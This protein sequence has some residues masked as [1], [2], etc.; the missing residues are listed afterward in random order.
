MTTVEL[1]AML[2]SHQVAIDGARGSVGKFRDLEVGVGAPLETLAAVHRELKAAGVNASIV[3]V[4]NPD[5]PDHGKPY[6][7]VPSWWL[8]D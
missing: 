5:H 3:R 7:E 4:T 8:T 2:A 6:V 1:K